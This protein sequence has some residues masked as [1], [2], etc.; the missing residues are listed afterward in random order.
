M[1]IINLCFVAEEIRSLLSQGRRAE[2]IELAAQNLRRGYHTKQFLTAAA[3]S[4][5]P[6][7][8]RRGRPRVAQPAHWFEIG[9]DFEALRGE[10]PR[11]SAR[12]DR[13]P[14]GAKIRLR[15]A[16]HRRADRLLPRCVGSRSVRRRSL[17][18]PPS[19]AI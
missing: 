3:D 12:R 6:Q 1:A 11:P 16:N 18:A 17:K 4:L 10:L 7:K 8:R 13:S 2:A 15:G 5:K 14:T 9:V 19:T